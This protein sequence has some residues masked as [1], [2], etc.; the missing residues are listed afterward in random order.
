M[1]QSPDHF[2]QESNTKNNE[3]I[4]NINDFANKITYELAK[5]TNEIAFF[6]I[7]DKKICEYS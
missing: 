7:P 3:S 5:N 1:Q 2:L 4:D 6:I